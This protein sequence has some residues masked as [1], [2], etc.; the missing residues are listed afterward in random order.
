MININNIPDSD[1]WRINKLEDSVS[2]IEW[3]PK[4]GG[5]VRARIDSLDDWHYKACENVIYAEDIGW[6]MIEKKK[7][8][9]AYIDNDGY[10]FEPNYWGA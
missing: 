7:E 5:W 4:V 8:E 10:T 3:T 2:D 1:Y 6:N 9:L